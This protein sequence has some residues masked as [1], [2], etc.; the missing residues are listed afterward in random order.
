MS[1][2]RPNTQTIPQVVIVGRPNVGKSTLFNRLV[3]FRKS[4]VHDEPGVTR[5]RIEHLC[6]WWFKGRERPVRLIDTGG[7]G[8]ERFAEEIKKQVAVALEDADLVIAL[9]D[10]RAGLENG[11]KE[12]VPELKKSGVRQHARVFCV[13][14][15]VDAEVHEALGAEFYELDLDEVLTISAEHGRGVEDLKDAVCA[16][17]FPLAGTESEEPAEESVEAEAQEEL[18]ETDAAGSDAASHD[19]DDSDVEGLETLESIESLEGLTSAERESLRDL[20]PEGSVPRIAV[21]GRPNVGKST[22]VNALLGEERMIASPVA[23]TTVDAVDSVVELSGK[24]YVIVDTAGIRRKSKTEQGIEVLSVVQAKKALERADIAILLLD[25]EKGL[26]DQDEK[27]GGLIEEAGCAVILAMN[28]WDT[29]QGSKF[30]KEMAAERIRG[31]M[32]FL[33]YAPILFMSGKRRQGLKNLGDLIEEILHQRRLRIPTHEFTTWVRKEALIHNPM[34][35]KFFLCHQAGRHPPTFVCHVNDPGR[36]HFSLQRHFVNAMRE[37]WGF[38]GSPIRL[39]FVSAKDK[40]KK[41]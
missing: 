40:S 28:K 32:G 22:L 20:P 41:K 24:P 9:F 27:I 10:A 17:L 36:V 1:A 3:G 26:T 4:L 38:M 5:D 34:N 13:V 31:K 8:H 37:R 21:V 7:L 6:K 33:K 35:A 30:T 2:P 29:Q 12:L 15:K 18:E 23:G 16:E 25:G 19:I 14:N 11:D 39:L